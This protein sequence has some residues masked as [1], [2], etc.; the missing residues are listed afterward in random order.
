MTIAGSTRSP[1]ADLNSR[2]LALGHDPFRGG[3]VGGGSSVATLSIPQPRPVMVHEC[4]L[5]Q[6][7]VPPSQNSCSTTVRH[8]HDMAAGVSKLAGVETS[9]F[10]FPQT[11]AGNTTVQVRQG[12]VVRQ[13]YVLRPKSCESAIAESLR[14]ASCSS[15]FN[16]HNSLSQEHTMAAKPW[17]IY[18]RTA[19]RR[20]L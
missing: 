5:L 2:L 20:C 7:L 19:P 6:F 8:R 1:A 16:D 11:R 18:A 10:P 3:S 13:Q 15:C 12:Q 9:V 4:C 17:T 14:S